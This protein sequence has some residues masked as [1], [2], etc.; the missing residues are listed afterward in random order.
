MAPLPA[1]RDWRLWITVALLLSATLGLRTLSHG[2][3]MVLRI[4]LDNFPQ[5]V[6][7]WKGVDIAI[8]QD[9]QEVLGA[10]D[11]LNRVYRDSQ[12]RNS[13]GLFVGYFGSQQR[14]GAIHSPKNCLPGAGWTALQGGLAAIDIPGYPEPVN[15][16]RYIIQKGLDKQLVLYWY[17]SQGRIIASEYSAKVYLVWDAVTKNRTDGALVRILTPIVEEDEAAAL[18]RATRFVQESFPHLMEFIPS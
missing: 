18:E 9:V 12:N 5:Q 1:N 4:K 7:I 3:P 16:N 14:G 15:V 2:T 10:S 17:Q 11:L 6:G 8:D 13:I